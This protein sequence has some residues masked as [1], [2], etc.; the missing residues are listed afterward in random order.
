[1]PP[2]AVSVSMPGC[3]AT[4]QLCGIERAFSARCSISSANCRKTRD[5]SPVAQPC[6]QLRRRPSIGREAE[7]DLRVADGD[8][9]LEAEH[10]VDATD[11]VAALLQ[12]LLQFAGFLE[13]DFRNVRAAPVHGG[14]R[15]R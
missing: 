2:G 7:L 12:K 10:A 9:A 1:M 11:V 3:A 5:L 6:E 8:A 14:P 13:G 4:W 15:V